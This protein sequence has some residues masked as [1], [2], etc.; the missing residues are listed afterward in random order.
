M[1]YWVDL[2]GVR[3]DEGQQTWLQAFPYGTY[4]HPIYGEIE[5][6]PQK[7]AEMAANVQNKVRGQDLDIDYDHK[8]H[9]GEAAGWVRGAEARKDGLWVAVQ[10]TGEALKKL[11]NKAYRYFSPEFS[12]EWEDPRTKTKHK[13]VL[14]GGALTNRPFLKDILP[15]N[16]SEIFEAKGPK[17]ASVTPEQIAQMRQVLGLPETAG[18]AEIRAAVAEK[19]EGTENGGAENAAGGGGEGDTGSGTESGQGSTGG[20]ANIEAPAPA[21]PAPTAVLP[22]AASENVTQLQ[23]RIAQLEAANRLSEVNAKL[24]SWTTG[25]HILPIALH[26]DARKVLLN[27]PTK[28]AGDLAAF[29]DKLLATGTVELGE[30]GKANTSGEGKTAAER[31][32]TEIRK[33]TE[34]GKMSYADAVMKISAEDP[35]LFEEYRQETF[36][37]E[38]A[39]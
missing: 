26:E 17:G 8:M 35:Q 14:F 33:L 12:D 6:T 9:S 36:T 34:G 27:A 32:D 23:E 5:M 3:F 16:L 24:T 21:G 13:N 30:R 31:Y 10:W 18:L 22:I 19:A 38:G 29:I 25:K 1:G 15:I 11:K 7:A 2:S 28:V 20:E 4:H 37:K 39:S